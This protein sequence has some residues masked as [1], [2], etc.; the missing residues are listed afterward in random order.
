MVWNERDEQNRGEKK[1]NVLQ[2][3]GR[4]VAWS[5]QVLRG[6]GSLRGTGDAGRVAKNGQKGA[7]SFLFLVR[8]TF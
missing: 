1:S 8:G 4:C 3:E 5:A 6:R 7:K 2:M